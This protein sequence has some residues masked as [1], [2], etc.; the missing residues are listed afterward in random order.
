MS[1][2]D[3][4]NALHAAMAEASDH[5]AWERLRAQEA[6]EDAARKAA[7]DELLASETPEAEAARWSYRM[8][9]SAI[10]RRVVHYPAGHG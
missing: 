1:I 5:P 10:E 2:D 9:R 8:R 3:A 7:S 6:A 4:R